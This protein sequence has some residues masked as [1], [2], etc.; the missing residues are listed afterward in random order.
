MTVWSAGDIGASSTEL[1]VAPGDLVT[2]LAR[3]RAAD[4]GI[5]IVVGP[6]AMPQPGASQPAAL[7]PPRT[8]SPALYRRGVPLPAAV[9]PGVARSS[10]VVVVGAGHVGTITAAR[11]AE[12]DVLGEVVLVDVVEGLAEGIALDLTHTAAL[13]GFST[14]VRGTT[15]VEE[16]GQ[17][18]YVVITA[19][20]ARQPGMSR[21]D[22]VGTNAAIVGDVAE[23][24]ARTSPRAVLLVVTNPLDEMTQHAWQASGFPPER[25]L[26][27]AGVLD[28]AR[29]RALVALTGVARAD[30]IEA[31]ALGSH[32]D[33]MVIPLSQAHAAGRPLTDLLDRAT[34]DAVVAR[35][36]GSGGEVVALL[37]QGSA[38]LAPGTSAARMVLA[39]VADAGEVLPAAVLADGCY[40]IRDVYLGLPARLSRSGLA[41]IVE[42][43][44]TPD[45]LSALRQAAGR[46][47]ERL[48]ALAGA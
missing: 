42:L 10:R 15:T 36:R 3:E 40:G 41:E 14:R 47:R 8:P 38:F 44:L 27:M 21:S 7:E 32:G 13:G 23:R 22:L 24:V 6:D 37:K 4:L 48:G 33:E 20:R 39:M 45:E 35:T 28:T 46:V 31:V 5:C 9:R 30:E 25:V 19:G 12:A 17:A 11:L 1:R 18:H 26:G 2:P 16:A 29:F 43:A 34:L